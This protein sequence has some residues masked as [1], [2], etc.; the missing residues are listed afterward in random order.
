M[1]SRIPFQYTY[2]LLR[3]VLIN[4]SKSVDC[5]CKS[6]HCKAYKP[7]GRKNIFLHIPLS[8]RH[9][10]QDMQHTRKVTC[11]TLAYCLYLPDRH[12]SLIPF[13]W[14]RACLHWSDVADNNALYIGL[15][16][17]CPILLPDINTIS[18]SWLVFIAVP[19]IKFCGKLTIGSCGD[20]CGQT[21]W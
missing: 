18:L 3:S 4:L 20:T 9:I 13:C 5:R 19:N 21:D 7:H 16:I 12:N 1:D 11:G 6:Y 10:G 14:Y 17:K 8:I 15:H 2:F